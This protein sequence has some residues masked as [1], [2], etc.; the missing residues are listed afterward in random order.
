MTAVDPYGTFTVQQTHGILRRKEHCIERSSDALGWRSM[1]CSMQR[2][3]PYE[4]SFEAIDDHLVVVHRDGPVQVTRRMGETVVKKTVAPGGLFILPAGHRFAVELGG[5]LSTIHIYV[6]R[7][8]VAD[9]AREVLKGGDSEIEL[10]PRFGVHDPLIE[11]AAYKAGEMVR[12]GIDSDWAVA[13]LARTIALQLVTAHATASHVGHQ[14][15]DGLSAERL[16][17]IREFIA[18]NLGVGISLSDM[19]AEVALSP[20]HFSRQFKRSV[21]QTPHQFLL[22]AR[23]AAARRLLHGDQSLAEIAYLCGFSHQEHMTRLFR[24]ELGITPGAYRKA[25]ARP[26]Q[27]G[28]R[29]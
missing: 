14:S 26:D 12:D 10:V 11:Q 3:H 4:D 27:V 28:T 16:G 25:A 21:G 19:A 9:A 22:A 8:V 29:R 15:G 23:V 17:R 1:Y 6:R 5:A 18:L 24:R 2:E 13:C 20:V 7:Q